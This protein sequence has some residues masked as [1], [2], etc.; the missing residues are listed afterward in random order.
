V[1]RRNDDERNADA[2]EREREDDD[3]AAVRLTRAI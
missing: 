1:R 2:D 3:R